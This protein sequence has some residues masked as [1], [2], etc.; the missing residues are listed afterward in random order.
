MVR[1]DRTEAAERGSGSQSTP[2]PWHKTRRSRYPLSK[3]SSSEANS[4]VFTQV[5]FGSSVSILAV[6]DLGYRLRRSFCAQRLLAISSGDA[7]RQVLSAALNAV[8][9]AESDEQL[10]AGRYERSESRTDSR[11][12]PRPVLP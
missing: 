2:Q 6:F 8:M 1:I 7:F 4:P 12:A 10:G 3:T 5:F 9:R 11:K